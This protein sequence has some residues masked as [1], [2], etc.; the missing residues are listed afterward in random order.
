[1]KRS[2]EYLYNY[3]LYK[4]NR[5]LCIKT[6]NMISL[7]Q[8]VHMSLEKDFHGKSGNFYVCLYLMIYFN[9]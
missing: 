3:D 7:V 4:H 1:M 8:V 2:E 5:I 6:C 9:N